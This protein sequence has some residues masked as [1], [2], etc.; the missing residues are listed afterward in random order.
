MQE[1]LKH[2]VA[3]TARVTGKTTSGDKEAQYTIEYRF[4]AD[5]C[6][7]HCIVSGSD[8]VTASQYASTQIG[9]PVPVTYMPD[10]P[11]DFEEGAITIPRVEAAIEQD[12][13]LILLGPALCLPALALMEYHYAG[14][15]R[16]LRE[17]IAV[18]A[19]VQARRT[20][21]GGTMPYT[22]RYTF[23]NPITR[24]LVIREMLVSR[25][26]YKRNPEGAVFTLLC[27]PDIYCNSEPYFKLT[28][29]EVAG[30]VRTAF[31]TETSP[32]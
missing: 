6:T 30:A 15:R 25:Q 22:L 21:A 4:Q 17:G 18:P 19:T 27:L 9:D 1:L 2:G 7:T 16:L 31:L 32:E 14:R 20:G 23:S 11:Q 29:V 26:E 8:N 12:I 13:F 10:N 5:A 24:E 28:E 3:A